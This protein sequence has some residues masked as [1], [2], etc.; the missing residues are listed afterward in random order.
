MGLSKIKIV[1][2]NILLQ[3]SNNCIEHNN[4]L[5]RAVFQFLKTSISK[6]FGL[7][8]YKIDSIIEY[9]RKYKHEYEILESDRMGYSWSSVSNLNY[10]NSTIQNEK[11][12]DI[13]LARVK[14]VSITSNSDLIID[15][16]KGVVLNDYCANNRDDN[17]CYVDG[18]TLAY[19]RRC[20]LLKTPMTQ[21]AIIT[22]IM[23]NG[24]FSFNYYHNIYENLIRFLLLEEYGNKIPIHVPVI[25]DSEI[26]NVSSL[27]QIVDY[28][29]KKTGRNFIPISRNRLYVVKELFYFSA[30][31]NLT[32]QHLNPS[33]GKAV[34]FLFDKLYI[35]KYARE[36]ILMKS[37]RVFPPKVF[38]T[39]ANVNKRNYNEDDVFE[40]LK[41]LGFVKIA[42]ETFSFEDQI[43]LF[44]NAKYIIGG[45]GA[46]FTNMLFSSKG[47]K[48]LIIIS[49][50][51][52]PSACFNA[53]AFIN[54][55][56]ILY[57]QCNKNKGI[58]ANFI[59]DID[60]FR[61]FVEKHVSPYCK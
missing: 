2:S 38:I 36:L 50:G 3:L 11:L 34:D 25:I 1:V 13:I 19:W 17:K 9:C 15:G 40:I 16:Q 24:K 37:Q 8:L 58:H 52:T 46:A 29:I 21:D 39:R 51:G 41:P 60:D 14:N 30:I 28:F 20:C 43:A 4:Y 7:K 45:S 6:I 59:V 18:I 44:N 42:P 53:P 57:Y 47:C 54:G 32:P 22:G 55:A 23:L 49:R 10:L 31:N 61:S 48:A 33:I 35:Q 12:L 5:N 56:E 27:K 26:L